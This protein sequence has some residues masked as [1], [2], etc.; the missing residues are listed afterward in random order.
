MTTLIAAA[1][2]GAVAPGQAVLATWHQLLD[3]GRL[4]DH[5]PFLAGTA[6]RPVARISAATADEI[7]VVTGDA[8]TV[9]TDA[10]SITLPVVLS[11]LPDHV[12]W[13]PTNSAGSAVRDALHADAGALVRLA[14]AS[15][16]LARELK[17][18]ERAGA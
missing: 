1:S 7:G 3:A 8:V 11:A 9:S 12:V 5:E 10:G 17:T 18:D 15:T 2:G 6:K 4:Q 13:L 14:A 16:E